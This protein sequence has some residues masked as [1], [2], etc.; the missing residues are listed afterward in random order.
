MTKKHKYNL[1][2]TTLFMLKDRKRRF[3]MS[4]F[5]DPIPGSEHEVL[6]PSQVNEC[7]TSC[8]LAGYGPVAGITPKPK[9]EW[10]AYIDRCFG[11]N[12]GNMF[13]F[14]FDGGWKSDRL[15]AAKRVLFYV[16]RSELE[17][18][19]WSY[20]P[21]SGQ[22]SSEFNPYKRLTQRQIENRLRK[23]QKE[24]N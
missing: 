9:E 14:L 24:F 6:M 1:I 23:L 2:T 19:S 17:D 10:G 22:I 11:A 18:G 4:G 13:N 20:L 8:C 7:G 21:S 15:F 3:E 16:E 12:D 5:T